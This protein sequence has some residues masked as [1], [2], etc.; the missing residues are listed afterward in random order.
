MYI[1]S[2]P[3]GLPSVYLA[4]SAMPTQTSMELLS[5]SPSQQD[6]AH[7]APPPS[8]SST[9]TS[10]DGSLVELAG[11]LGTSR[12]STVVP[13]TP[14]VTETLPAESGQFSSGMY[15]PFDSDGMYV[16]VLV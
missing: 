8:G 13:E 12:E 5:P 6:H 7:P 10:L 2:F 4:A 3:Q 1:C 14:V 11:S 15:N 9:T 16:H